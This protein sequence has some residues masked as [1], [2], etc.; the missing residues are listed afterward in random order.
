MAFPHGEQ[1]YFALRVANARLESAQA[2]SSQDSQ[3]SMAQIDSVPSFYSLPPAGVAEQNDKHYCR[4][5]HA[6]PSNQKRMR[7]LNGFRASSISRL[8]QPA[9]RSVSS[10]GVSRHC[11]H[12]LRGE[13]GRSSMSLKRARPSTDAASSPQSI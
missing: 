5:L 9:A 1:K 12:L 10:K 2:P 3:K 7:R 11:K 13:K 8:V 6:P 4:P